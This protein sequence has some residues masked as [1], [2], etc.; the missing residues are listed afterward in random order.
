MNARGFG[1]VSAGAALAGLFHQSD[2]AHSCLDPGRASY[3]GFVRRDW[4]NR[5]PGQAQ[6]ETVE[7]IASDSI[8][9][10]SMT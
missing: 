8:A 3:W 7:S 10:A 1:F 4:T 6:T 2:V 9:T 5:I